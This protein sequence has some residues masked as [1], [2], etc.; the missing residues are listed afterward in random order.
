MNLQILKDV[1]GSQK[2]WCDNTDKWIRAEDLTNNQNFFVYG[3]DG[4]DKFVKSFNT[5]EELAKGVQ[6]YYDGNTGCDFETVIYLI[7][8]NGKKMKTSVT[9]IDA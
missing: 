8:Q 3:D 9:L 7:V 4:G 2:L 5:A 6:R 1:F